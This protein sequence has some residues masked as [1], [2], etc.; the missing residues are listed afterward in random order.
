MSSLVTAA[1]RSVAGK[2][3]PVGVGHAQLAPAGVDEGLLGFGHG[4]E[5]Y[6]TAAT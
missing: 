4:P 5:F 1:E 3:T 6:A 2:I